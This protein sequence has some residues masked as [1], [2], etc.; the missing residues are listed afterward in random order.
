MKKRLESL[1]S[2]DPE[3]K[4]LLKAMETYRIDDKKAIGIDETS[5]RRTKDSI[6][7]GIFTAASLT[8]A[9]GYTSRTAAAKTGNFTVIGEDV[10]PDFV[11]DFIEAFLTDENGDEISAASLQRNVAVILGIACK[12]NKENFKNDVSVIIYG[13]RALCFTCRGN[14]KHQSH[15]L[16]MGVLNRLWAA[17]NT[18]NN[19]GLW[20]VVDAV[21]LALI[22][23]LEPPDDFEQEVVKSQDPVGLKSDSG[24]IKT[25]STE[26]VN[27]R[28]INIAPTKLPLL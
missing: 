17:L 11:K 22:G 1:L 18:G 7:H 14:S 4:L 3:L 15:L 23:L 6:Q 28:K 9:G 24:T 5:N 12:A 26:E 8:R 20:E 19:R 2:C 16:E 27:L 13:C 21:V 25:R 10:V